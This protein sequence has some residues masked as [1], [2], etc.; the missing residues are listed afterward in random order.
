MTD[1]GLAKINYSGAEKAPHPSMPKEIPVPPFMMKAL[2][3]NP[4]AWKNFSA[5]AP[6]Y[7]RNYTGWIVMAKRQETREKRLKEAIDLLAQGKK[8]GL[9]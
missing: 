7:R 4:E 6:S 8:L 3:A 1:I 5:L 9:K 2:K